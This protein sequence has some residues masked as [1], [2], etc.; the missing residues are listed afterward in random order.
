MQDALVQD[1]SQGTLIVSVGM[2]YATGCM[3]CFMEILRARKK[4]SRGKWID[5]YLN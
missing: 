2:D 4:S 5:K 1:L 3:V